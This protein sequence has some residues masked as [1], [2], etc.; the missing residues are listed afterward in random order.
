M[1]LEIKIASTN[2]KEITTWSPTTNAWNEKKQANKPEITEGMIPIKYNGTKWVT[3]TED[4]E[5]WYNYNESGDNYESKWANIMLSDGK[6]K[7]DTVLPGTEVEESDLGS[8]FV[9]IPRY[10]YKIEN[11]YHSSIAGDISIE[12]LEGT[13]SHKTGVDIGSY[14]EYSYSTTASESKMNNYVV[15]PAFNYDET[16]LTGI[17]IA[18]FRASRADA[19]DSSSGSSEQ[20]KVV[21]NKYVY[22]NIN[23]GKM[24][25]ACIGMNDEGN[26]YGLTSNDETVD[27]HLMK[28]TEWGAM[29]YL[30]QSK[31][32]LNKTEADYSSYTKAGIEYQKN[33]KMGSTR[34]VYGIYDLESDKTSYNLSC[35]EVTAAYLNNKNSNLT[36]N[37]SEINISIKQI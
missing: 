25:T 1:R 22:S 37:G 29:A 33:T 28:N 13:S 19:T 10:A 6:Y 27:P 8:M 12:F 16:Q 31:Y 36:M 35:H 21:G 9:W 34:N 30:T 4:D 20:I 3:T 26:S 18:K 17:W 24:Y 32:G 2:T 11:G 7:S 14:P 15:H 23:I 5:D